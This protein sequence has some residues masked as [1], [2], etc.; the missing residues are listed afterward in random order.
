VTTQLSRVY[1]LLLKRVAVNAPRLTITGLN[2]VF[3]RTAAVSDRTRTIKL[4]CA[5]VKVRYN[6][7]VCVSSEAF[8][9][10]TF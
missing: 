9:L 5:L 3:Q 6:T 2:N 1:Y 4:L 10:V 7:L 8:T